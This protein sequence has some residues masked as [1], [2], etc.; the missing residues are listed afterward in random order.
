[1]VKNKTLKRNMSYKKVRNIN[2]F[3][4]ITNK[5]SNN[6]YFYTIQNHVIE[7]RLN[8]HFAC[9]LRCNNNKHLVTTFTSSSFFGGTPLKNTCTIG[10]TKPQYFSKEAFIIDSKNLPSGFQYQEINNKDLN[11]NFLKEIINDYV[12]NSNPI[13][14]TIYDI[15]NS[16]AFGLQNINSEDVEENITR[17]TFSS[18]FEKF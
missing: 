3:E 5:L 4:L 1:M 6:L 10:F 7:K 2:C 13:N 14:V 8:S 16:I 12:Y 11:S 9:I 15:D 18:I 17:T